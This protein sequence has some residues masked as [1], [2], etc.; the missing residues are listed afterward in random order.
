MDAGRLPGFKGSSQRLVVCLMRGV[1]Y[2]RRRV[3]HFRMLPECG[4]VPV[5]GCAEGHHRRL[6]AVS[7]C[8]AG[9]AAT[10][11]LREGAKRPSAGWRGC[12]RETRPPR[13][14]QGAIASLAD[15]WSLSCDAGRLR[16]F[17]GSCRREGHDI[18][19]VAVPP[20]FAFGS[21]PCEQRRGRVTKRVSHRAGRRN[22]RDAIE[23][24]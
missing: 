5:I 14:R 10:G 20:R 19:R 24:R 12:P 2:C 4:I 17:S 13:M 15:V 8:F 16:P 18:A 3:A 21:K 9:T 23:H 22:C 6:T 7:M 11:S 1:N